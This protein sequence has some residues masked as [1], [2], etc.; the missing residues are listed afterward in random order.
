LDDATG[1]AAAPVAVLLPAVAEGATPGAYGM[2][3]PRGLEAGC[4]LPVLWS[5]IAELAIRLF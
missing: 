2:K 4:R 3:H 5:A 1:A